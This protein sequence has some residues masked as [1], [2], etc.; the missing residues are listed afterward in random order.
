MTYDFFLGK[1]ALNMFVQN[2]T[3]IL[4]IKNAHGIIFYD[5]RACDDL[6]KIFLSNRTIP[7]ISQTCR[8]KVASKN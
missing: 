1:L 3:G 4:L 8:I 2:V 7:L 5:Q 6:L